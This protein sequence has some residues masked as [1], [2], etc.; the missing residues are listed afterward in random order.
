[1]T[2]CLDGHCLIIATSTGMT[3]TGFPGPGA[4]ASLIANPMQ[5]F[6]EPDDKENVDKMFEHFL[7]KHPKHYVNRVDRTEH[8]YRKD[9]FR[10]NLR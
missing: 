2:L 8:N 1:M 3:C 9:V 4:E 7:Q 6:I 10:Q 5:E